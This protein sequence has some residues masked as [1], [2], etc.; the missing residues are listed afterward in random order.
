MPTPESYE[1]KKIDKYL[2]GIGAY[3]VATTTFG[4]GHSGT[5]DRIGCVMGRFFAIEVKREG[6]KPTKLQE[7]RIEEVQKAGGFACYG[8]AEKVIREFDGWLNA[9]NR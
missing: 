9:N 5:S 6:A 7:H 8:T 2:R 4:F 1:K 3:F